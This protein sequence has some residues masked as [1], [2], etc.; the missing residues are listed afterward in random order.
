MHCFGHRLDLIFSTSLD[1]DMACWQT[2]IQRS[3]YALATT[4]HG[5]E[6]DSLVDEGYFVGWIKELT[7]FFVQDGKHC[8]VV[9]VLYGVC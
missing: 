7:G 3:H 8:G 2:V 4:W 9:G 5:K 6:G 1:T